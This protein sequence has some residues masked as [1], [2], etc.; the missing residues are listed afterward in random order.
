MARQSPR[1]RFNSS[2]LVRVLAGLAE[3]EAVESRQSI[4]ERLGQW[5]GVTDALPLS[6]V[7]DAGTV[8]AS[9][10]QP[11]ASAGGMGARDA[12]ERVRAALL[13][14]L[15]TNGIEVMSANGVE[16]FGTADFA[17]YRRHY[18]ARQRDMRTSIGPLRAAVRVELARQSP[19]LRQ[20]AA[21]DAV[22]D[23]A[24]V[25]RERTLL[26]TVPTLL[27][28]RF[29]KLYEAHRAKLAEAQATDDP[30][31][32]MAPGGWLARFCSEMRDVL[33]AELEL[34]LQPIAGLVAALDNETT[35]SQ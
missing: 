10:V 2:R 4:A 3:T 32:W 12:F 21:L 35:R 22:L 33:L 29:G 14:A 19:R 13:D 23:Q 1:A 9:S 6:S 34:R 25:D 27:S 17:P 11:A 31:R 8:G 20:L 15:S 26:A 7:L 18:L 28:L 24:L 16:G 30:A 5:L